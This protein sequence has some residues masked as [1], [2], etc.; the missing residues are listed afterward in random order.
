VIA[1]VDW[2]AANLVLPAVVSMSLGTSSIDDVLDAAVVALIGLGVQVITAAGNFNNS[3]SDLLP[4]SP[5][6]PLLP[7]VY[8][9]S[10]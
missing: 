10:W 3:R 2:V 6:P 5:P 4:P 7:M 9:S 1:G 8:V